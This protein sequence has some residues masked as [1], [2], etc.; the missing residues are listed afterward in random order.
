[1]RDQIRAS[2][3]RDL[4][5][6]SQRIQNLF[7]GGTPTGDPFRQTEEMKSE[8]PLAISP[9][10]GRSFSIGFGDEPNPPEA[11]DKKFFHGVWRGRFEIVGMSCSTEMIFQP[12][13]DY[14]TFSHSDNGWYAFRAVGTW[15]LLGKGNI[16]IHYIDHD[17][18]EW[19]KKK[20]DFP[21]NENI[22][23]QVI[24]KNKVKSSLCEWQRFPE[25]K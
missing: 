7:R 24:H 21:E 6:S 8:F 20:L 16:Q 15:Q 14:S 11:D 22:H 10:A 9:S 1:M 3:D 19:N 18:K 4:A 13:G 17:P 2:L 23:F 25:K 12:N 5:A